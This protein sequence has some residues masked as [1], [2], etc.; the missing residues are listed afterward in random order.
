M[1]QVNRLYWVLGSGAGPSGGA[2]AAIEPERIVMSDLRLQ[3][4]AGFW[5]VVLLVPLACG[6]AP[7]AHADVFE[8]SGGGQLQGEWLNRGESSTAR[9][10]M[11]TTQGVHIVLDKVSVVQARDEVSVEQQYLE[12]TTRYG[13]DVAGQWAVAE[14][15]RE[16]GLDRQRRQHLQRI[17][18][19]EPDHLGARRA[20]GYSQVSGRWVTREESM[21]E[22]GYVLYR[23]KW[24]L[25][26]QVELMERQ[27]RR[28]LAERQWYRQLL[29]WR[30]DLS[31]EQVV[32]YG[33]PSWRFAIRVL[34]PR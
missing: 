1:P 30:R 20:L 7:V 23:G 14:W 16:H 34:C 25:S 32:R 4:R 12:V 22:R 5:P 8:L 10:E 33:M 28:A 31:T 27:R 19:L 26:Q 18:E 6:G 3:T 2:D 24:Y 17:L 11:R 21:R 15:C 9:Y 29:R 13:Q